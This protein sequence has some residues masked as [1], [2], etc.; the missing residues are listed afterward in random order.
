M[1]FIDENKSFRADVYG[2]G[3]GR[4]SM[5]LANLLVKN[6]LPYEQNKIERG[7]SEM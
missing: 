3:F 5:Q 4:I 6:S 7:G 2:S 1:R